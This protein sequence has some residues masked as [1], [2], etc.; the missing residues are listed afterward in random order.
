MTTLIDAHGHVVPPSFIAAC[1]FCGCTMDTRDNT[2]YQFTT[3][4][5]RNKNRGN[6]ITLSKRQHRWAC[7][8]CV[9]KLQHGIPIGQMGLWDNDER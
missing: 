8:E 9:D 4:W 5:A 3:G 7:R 6:S 1:H 2:A